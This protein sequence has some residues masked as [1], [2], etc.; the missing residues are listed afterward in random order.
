LFLVERLPLFGVHQ[1]TKEL[2]LFLSSQ[3]ASHSLSRG[4]RRHSAL[5]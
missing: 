5:G 3:N 4:T 2:T 1:W